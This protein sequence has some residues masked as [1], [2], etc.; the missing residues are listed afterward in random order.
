MAKFFMTWADKKQI[1]INLDL[2]R[3]MTPH[4]SNPQTTIMT[5]DA[6]HVVM[7]DQPIQAFVNATEKK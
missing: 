6:G 5:F 3:F 2:V 4:A 7:V 1:A